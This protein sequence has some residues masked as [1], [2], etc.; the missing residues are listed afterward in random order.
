MTQENRNCKV[1]ELSHKCFEIEAIELIMR[2]MREVEKNIWRVDYEWLREEIKTCFFYHPALAETFLSSIKSRVEIPF[3]VRGGLLLG[4]VIRNA[5]WSIVEEEFFGLYGSL[6]VPVRFLFQDYIWLRSFYDLQNQGDWTLAP[7]EKVLEWIKSIE[8]DWILTCYQPKSWEEL[9]RRAKV[10]QVERGRVNWIQSTLVNGAFV[11][12][13]ELEEI[14]G[15]EADCL[16][17][18]VNHWR[19]AINRVQRRDRE[20]IENSDLRQYE[21]D[22]E[23]MHKWLGPLRI[24]KKQET[25]THMEI[26]VQGI[27]RTYHFRYQKKR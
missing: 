6:Q 21:A 11:L 26:A 22:D 7:I 10:V 18:E 15:N 19:I 1:Y 12:P 23:I 14:W 20:G 4:L 16:V 13:K 27:L 5:H 3:H 25:Q 8:T 24:L 2:S 9:D 17:T